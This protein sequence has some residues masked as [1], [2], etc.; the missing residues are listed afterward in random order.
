MSIT[1]AVGAAVSGALGDVVGGVAGA[2]FAA[3]FTAAGQWV[4]TGAAWLLGQVGRAMS[5]TTTVD[6]SSGWFSAH[7]SVMA[8]MVAAVV[9]PMVCCAALQALYRQSASMLA[10]AFLVQLPLALLL[11][12]VAVELVQMALAVTDRVLMLENAV[13]SVITVE[14]CAIILWKDGKSPEMREK[15]AAALHITAQDLLELRVI[16]EI[17]PEPAG[18]AQA[19][20]ETTAKSL[21]Q[22]LLRNLDD[23]RHLKPDKLVRRRREKYLRIGQFSE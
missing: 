18:G 2:G 8:T 6:L 5:A 10:R 19:D 17:V 9:L 1:G 3:V 16:D 15:A 4:A 20:H 23:L 13:Y 22:A 7:E 21:Q 11:T 14:G 12:G